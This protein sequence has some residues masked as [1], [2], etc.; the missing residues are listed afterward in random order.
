[1]GSKK[2]PQNRQEDF[3]AMEIIKLPAYHVAYTQTFDGYETGIPKA[4][5]KLLQIVRQQGL[6]NEDCT[7]IGVPYDNPGITPHARCRYRAC[8]TVPSN[9]ILKHGEVRTANI[10]MALYAIYHFN[11]TREDVADAYSFIFGEWL[12][13]SGYLP[14]ER[15]LIELYPMTLMSDCAQ[16]RLKYD[17]ALP[18]VQMPG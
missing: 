16:N 12:L 17:I 2:A 13:Q 7:L 3:D 6:L 8:I 9:I 15:Q 4:W 5:T 11:G 18:I 14:D 10:E 1:M